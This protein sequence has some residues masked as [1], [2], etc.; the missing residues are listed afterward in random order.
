MHGPKPTTM[1]IFAMAW[2]NVW[3]NRRRSLVTMFAMTLALCVELLYAG[4]IPGYLMGME[5]DVVETEVGDVQIHAEGYLDS[6]DLYTRIGNPDELLRR[7]DA[8]GYPASSRL[9]GGGLAAAGKLSSG[10]SFI[11]IDVERDARVSNISTRVDRGQWVDTSDASG[12]VVGHLVADNLGVEPGDE[13]VVMTQGADGSMAN[14]LYRVRGV[15]APVA[16]GT[17]RSAVFMN[18]DALRE[19]LVV[20][21]GSH[22]IVVRRPPSVSLEAATAEIRALAEEHDVQN[23]REL[24]PVIAQMLDSAKGMVYVIFFVLYIAVAILIL[25]AMLMAVFERIREFGMMKAL[26]VSPTRVV[27]IIMTESSVQIVISVVVGVLLA[28]PGMWYLSE[29][30]IDVGALGGTSTMGLAMRQV[31]YGIYGVD[32]VM[33]PIIMLVVMAL[34]ASLYPAVKAAR[35]EPVEAMRHR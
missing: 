12:V 26:G 27:A 32:T 19:L 28:S 25:N 1:K 3:R 35:L 2:R 20:P 30:G 16:E 11:G 31:W 5:N 6:P 21:S 8:A 13:F 14:E 33:G 7:L 22:R 4:L 24:M 34:V 18:I 29:V 10:V 23:W 9:S 17:D 15:L